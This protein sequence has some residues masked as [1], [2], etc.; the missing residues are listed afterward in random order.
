MGLVVTAQVLRRR[1]GRV[2][3]HRLLD[4]HGRMVGA[5]VVAAPAAAVVDRVLGDA[6]GAGWG[7]SLGTVGV[8]A[9]IGA[10][11]YALA[12]RLLRV[13]EF[14]TLVAAFRSR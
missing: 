4:A 13:T 14:G 11:L 5:A 9:V 3:G 2:D 1:I 8:A 7:G 10:G 12:A 6:V